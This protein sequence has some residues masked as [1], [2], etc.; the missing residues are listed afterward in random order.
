VAA[1][2]QLTTAHNEGDAD[3]ATVRLMKSGN[4]WATAYHAETFHDGGNGSTIGVNIEAHKKVDS[5]RSVGVNIQSVDWQIDG[6]TQDPTVV[7]RAISV[8]CHSKANFTTGLHFD[9][10]S[11]GMRALWIQG[12]WDVGIDTGDNCIRM[13]RGAELCFDETRR[14]YMSTTQKQ[15]G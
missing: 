12:R 14:F 1:Y 9:E 2:I 15:I 10:T 11:K 4:G 5:G 8:Q 7:D 6:S 13:N 3:G